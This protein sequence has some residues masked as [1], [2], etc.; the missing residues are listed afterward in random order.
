MANEITLHGADFIHLTERSVYNNNYFQHRETGEIIFEECDELYGEFTFYRCTENE[1][2]FLGRSEND[3]T[4]ETIVIH[5][6]WL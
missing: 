2:I 3:L 5:P 6:D 4:E 1:Q